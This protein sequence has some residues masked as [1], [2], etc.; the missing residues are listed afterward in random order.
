MTTPSSPPSST[1]P[2]PS[3]S[4]TATPLESLDP[5]ALASRGLEITPLD[6]LAP[7]PSE[8]DISDTRAGE[9]MELMYAET[10]TSGLDLQYRPD[11]EAHRIRLFH[12]TKPLTTAGEG[13]GK[14]MRERKPTP[15]I[16]FIHG[17]SWRSGTYLDSVGTS[18]I[19]HLTS[20]GYAFA[21]VNYRL[22]P[23]VTIE[24]QVQDVA[25]AVAFLVSP[26]RDGAA[27]LGVEIDTERV[28]LMGHSSGAHVAALLGTDVRYLKRAGLGTSSIKGVVL[29]DGSNYNATAELTDSPGPVADN[30][31]LG[32]GRDLS[33]LRALSPTLNVRVGGVVQ[34][35]LL[36]HVQR[37]GDIR[38]AVELEAVLRATDA[39][40]ELHVFEGEGFEGH[41]QMLLRL[42]LGEY[43]AT[44]VLERWLDGI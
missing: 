2:A 38:Q 39:Q 24:E 17:G 26:K 31:V 14:D 42:G 41:V 25:D 4:S 37:R 22:I 40:A 10:L 13:R 8:A 21:S 32:M 6:I 35:W 18:K 36:L 12:P 19:T 30:L 5:I 34:K 11:A 43:P 27:E 20:L 28:V 1:P 44:G 7:T 9:L 16:I 33:R 23:A 3:S 15:L 29:L